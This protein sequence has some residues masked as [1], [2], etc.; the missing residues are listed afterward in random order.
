MNIQRVLAV[1]AAV[2]IVCAVALGTLEVHPAELGQLLARMDSSLLD[3]LQRFVRRWCGAWAW[4]SVV[5]PLLQRPAWLPPAALALLAT[6]LAL[7]LAGRK[8]THRS[9]R[10]S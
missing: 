10:R 5:T 2:M 9:R 8:S 6:G 7:S 4:T 1:F 3:G